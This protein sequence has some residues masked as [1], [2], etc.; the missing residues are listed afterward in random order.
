[1]GRALPPPFGQNP[2]EKLLFF[3]KPSLTAATLVELEFKCNVDEKEGKYTEVYL[4]STS[5]TLLLRQ[6]LSLNLN[7][8]LMRR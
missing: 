7:A 3:V 4:P 2:K 8:M 6:W 1:M 5:S